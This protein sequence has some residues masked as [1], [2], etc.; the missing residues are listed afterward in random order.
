LETS[1]FVP[2]QQ[3]DEHDLPDQADQEAHQQRTDERVRTAEPWLSQGVTSQASRPIGTTAAAQAASTC[4][5]EY[6][7]TLS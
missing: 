5:T 3:H 6:C 2:D 1:L 7:V 4:A